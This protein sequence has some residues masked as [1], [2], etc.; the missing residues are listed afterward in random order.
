METRIPQDSLRRGSGLWGSSE[1]VLEELRWAVQGWAVLHMHGI[2][3]QLLFHGAQQHASRGQGGK[4][5]SIWK[6]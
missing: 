3:V 5:A 1:L 6:D 4:H 2:L